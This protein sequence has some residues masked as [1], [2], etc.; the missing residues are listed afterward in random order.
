M[1][2]ITETVKHLIIINGI[3]FFASGLL[4]GTFS[5]LMALHF[6]MNVSFQPWQPLTHMFMHGGIYHLFF[7]ML[8]LWMFGSPLEQMWGRQKFLFYYFSTGIGAAALQMAAYAFNF[9]SGVDALQA[10]GFSS[11]EILDTLVTGKY[12]TAWLEVLSQ[13][14]IG[15]LYSSYMSSMVGAS[16][17]LYGILVAFAFTFPEIPLMLLFIPFPIKAKYFVPLLIIGDLFFGFSSVSV[18]P[19]AHFAHVGGALTGFLMMYFWKRNQFNQ[20]RWD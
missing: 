19:I 6:Y 12:N 15:S 1:R 17:A 2:G 4:G 14:D 18:G 10:A 3:F 7:N 13:S 9:H 20:N 5:D 11:A 8:G 16:G